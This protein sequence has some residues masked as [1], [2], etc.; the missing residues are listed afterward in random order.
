MKSSVRIQLAK[1]FN[2]VLVCPRGKEAFETDTKERLGDAL[3]AALAMQCAL[4][5]RVWSVYHFQNRLP[6]ATRGN[7]RL[8]FKKYFSYVVLYDTRHIS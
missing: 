1:T 4:D 3:N 7:Y 5:L 2:V 6:T 8:D